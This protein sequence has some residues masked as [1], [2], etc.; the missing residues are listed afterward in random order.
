[1][2][3]RQWNGPDDRQDDCTEEW[4]SCECPGC[5]HYRDN[6]EPDPPTFDDALGA[7]G[8]AITQLE[9]AVRLKR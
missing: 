2:D 9:E 8:D 4:R 7:V 5:R 3:A 6:F 1:M